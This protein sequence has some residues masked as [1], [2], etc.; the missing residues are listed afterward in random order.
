MVSLLETKPLIG[1]A[2][3]FSACFGFGSNKSVRPTASLILDNPA[4]DSCFRKSLPR[5]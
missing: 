1:H 3:Y 2:N 5:G 4:R